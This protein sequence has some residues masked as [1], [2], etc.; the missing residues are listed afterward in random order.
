MTSSLVRPKTT[1]PGTMNFF[2][3][4]NEKDVPKLSIILQY[5]LG[6]DKSADTA[7]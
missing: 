7:E 2:T 4:R 6:K 3:S 5:S 1:Q